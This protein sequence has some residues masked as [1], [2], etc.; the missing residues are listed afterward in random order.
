MR[1]RT[2]E[3]DA[4]KSVYHPFISAQQLVKPRALSLPRAQHFPLAD[5]SPSFSQLRHH[6]EQLASLM[7]GI[8][9]KLATMKRQIMTG[10]VLAG[11][12]ERVGGGGRQ[13]RG[14]RVFE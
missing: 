7:G 3:R 14:I 8:A 2:G 6:L 5:I 11:E 1:G 4:L 12:S 13:K 9:S 10:R